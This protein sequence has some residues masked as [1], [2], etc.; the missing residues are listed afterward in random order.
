MAEHCTGRGDNGKHCCWVAGKVC[1][2]L[3][4]NVEGRNFSCSLRRELGSWEAVHEDPRYQPIAEVM[5]LGD[6]LCGDWQPRP[7]E[8]CR[9]E[10]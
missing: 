7:G 5:K 9:A 6:G 10:S 4:T 2:H 8:C 1:E 3:E